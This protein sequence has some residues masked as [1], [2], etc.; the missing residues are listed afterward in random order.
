[1]STFS[2]LK[3]IK[4]PKVFGQHFRTQTWKPWFAFLAAL[5]GLPMTKER[6]AIYTKHTGRTT[7]PSEPLSE[8]WLICGRRAGKSFILAIIA[9]FLA[10]FKDWRPYLGPGE[11]GTVMIVAR[12]RKQARVIKRYV[13]GLL[14]AVPMLRQVIVSETSEGIELQNNVVIEIHTASF[15]AIRGY[16]VVAAL[17][18]EIAFWPTADDAADPDAEVLNALRPATTVP[19]AMLLCASSPYARKGALWDAHRKHFGK[20]GDPILV[21]QARHAI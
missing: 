2:I 16:T 1:M 13:G 17:C 19:G 12:D 5:F 8:A 6:L 21:W 11:V 14:H 18:D 9:V 7:P 10:V 20:D 3:A 15:R 4:D